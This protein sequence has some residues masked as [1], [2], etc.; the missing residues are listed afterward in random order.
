MPPT[1]GLKTAAQTAATTTGPKVGDTKIIGGKIATYNGSSWV[2]GGVGAAPPSAPTGNIVIPYSSQTINGVK[3]HWEYNSVSPR[4]FFV[5]DTPTRSGSGGG[6]GGGAAT[7]LSATNSVADIYRLWMGDAWVA[8]HSATIASAVKN[9]WT[10]RMI[11][12]DAVGAGANT[13]YAQGMVA[14]IRGVVGPLTLA[15]VNNILSSGVWMEANF[16]TQI[17]PQYMTDILSSP[18][19]LPFIQSWNDYTAGAGL[20]TAEQAKLREIVTTFG[21]TAAA[22]AQWESWLTTTTAAQ[23]GNYGA[24][25]RAIITS[26]IQQWFGREPTAAELAPPSPGSAGTTTTTTVPGIAHGTVRSGSSGADVS[27]LQSALNA[28]GYT[29]TV[30]GNAGPATIAALKD[31]QTKN[32]LTSD[33]I[34]GAATWGLL[35]PPTT[36]TTTTPGVA[37]T[38]TYWSQIGGLLGQ[39]NTAAF[40]E[41]LRKTDEYILTF[42]PKSAGQSE[43]EYLS[44]RDAMNTVGNWYFN[45][46]PGVAGT[47]AATNFSGYTVEELARMNSDGWT[48]SGL[49]NYYQN[50]QEAAYN[51]DIYNPI[52]QEAFGTTFTDDDW[53]T[54]ANGGVGSGALKSQLVEAQNRVQFREA[55]RQVF[56]SD[57]APADYDR[58]TD[59]FI[60][61]SELIREVQ[62]LNSVD[63]IYADTNA[64]MQR[65]YGDGVTKDELI[66]VVLGRANTGELKALINTATKL[67]QFTWMHEQ[68]TGQTATPDDYAKYAGY[69][70]PAELQWEIVT[71]EAISQNRDT[72]KEAW[73][74]AYPDQPMITD[75]ELKTL[76]GEQE[77]YGSISAKVKAAQKIQGEKK[78]AEDW[79]RSGAQQADIG[80]KAGASGGF[81]TSAP[82]LAAL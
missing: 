45:D 62:A 65:V 25:K 14:Y 76:Y 4:G 37:G 70:G 38:A 40:L 74:A 33:G 46:T 77:G 21:Y 5:P 58:I 69:T 12:K 66:D 42:A 44:W 81:Q 80:Y 47:T 49:Q 51:R 29:L 60:S 20:G 39:Q 17:A 1:R 6:G 36:T 79:A 48:A 11:I 28:A 8:S 26:V 16:E 43:A 19:S 56:G 3:G 41:G 59:D 54:L 35:A 23:T 2:G 55:Y 7:S 73:T 13:P 53:Y 24:E 61:P 30:D 32:N 75:E 52:L 18:Q 15:A 22:Q 78:Q 82:G 31:Y 64:L 63:E 9:G 27:A 67:D 10:E 68:Y 34:A 50:V 57:P 72:I 71:N